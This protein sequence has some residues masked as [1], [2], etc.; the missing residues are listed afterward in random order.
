MH[1]HCWVG[2]TF[3]RILTNGI[4]VAHVTQNPA[5]HSLFISGIICK[6]TWT[7]DSWKIGINC[8]YCTHGCVYRTDLLKHSS[9]PF[10]YINICLEL[11]PSRYR[12]IFRNSAFHVHILEKIYNILTKVHA[13]SWQGV[14][15]RLILSKVLHVLRFVRNFIDE[16]PLCC[17]SEEISNIRKK[18]IEGSDELKLRQKTS[19]VILKVTQGQYYLKYNLIVPENYPDQQIK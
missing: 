17:C 9:S 10:F 7:L 6:G 5:V 2:E 8:K 16:N 1:C 14:N 15:L 12:I 13:L 18:L 4:S 11:C 3:L 19:S